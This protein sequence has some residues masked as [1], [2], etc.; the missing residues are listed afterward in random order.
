MSTDIDYKKIF[1]LALSSCIYR[2]YVETVFGLGNLGFYRLVTET[3][4]QRHEAALY[5]TDK[6]CRTDSRISVG[7]ANSIC[8]EPDKKVIEDLCFTFVTLMSNKY[9]VASA[10]ESLTQKILSSL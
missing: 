5:M 1:A 6:I 3:E 4:E 9:D 10:T 2:T 7:H 8:T